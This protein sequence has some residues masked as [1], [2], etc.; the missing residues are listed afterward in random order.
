MGV[1][2]VS[3]FVSENAL[4]GV[5]GQLEQVEACR[6]C[7]QPATSILLLD[8]EEALQHTAY[9]VTSVLSNTTQGTGRRVHTPLLAFTWQTNHSFDSHRALC[10]TKIGVKYVSIM[11]KHLF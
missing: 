2:G 4:L 1:D 6:R 11:L 3:E 10:W 9:S 5:V 7:G 8:V